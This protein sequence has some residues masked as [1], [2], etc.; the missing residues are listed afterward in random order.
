MVSQR[1]SCRLK[2][3]QLLWLGGEVQGKCLS[4]EGRLAVRGRVALGAWKPTE[5]GHKGR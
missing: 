5:D 4:W 3:N 1:E 2:W